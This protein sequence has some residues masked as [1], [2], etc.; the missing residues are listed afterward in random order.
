MGAHTA[1]DEIQ[2]AIKQVPT[3][4]K[5]ALKLISSAS[6]AM[7][8]SLLPGTLNS[9]SRLATDSANKANATLI[10][11]NNL[12]DLLGEIIELSASTQS[13]NE[14]EIDR[15]IEQQKN[16]TLEQ[17][18]LKETLA[19]IKK[20]YDE[21]KA[22]LEDARKKYA[23]AMAHLSASSNPEIIASGGSKPGLINQALN[24]IS[25]PFRGLGCILG[26]CTNPT[27]IVDN[28]KFENALHM[29][30]MAKEE[31][32]RAEALYNSHFLL[33]LEA[34]NELAKTINSMAML[35]LS[36]LS[37]EEIVRLLLEAAKQINLVKEQW[38]RMIRF[39]SK[40]AARAQSTQQ[41]TGS[42]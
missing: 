3:Q 29:A 36:Q 35:N 15:L 38:T 16:S 14:A 7:L 19:S 34:Q 17:D 27:Y 9:I 2:L 41:V 25:S 24:L 4:V 8:K 33:Q 23:Q 30:Q 39:F 37:T 21:S 20:E 12:Q 1:M 40:L 5:T 13:T 6:D 11:F 26:G 10:R 28:S 32:E 31:L 22:K 18:R 42:L